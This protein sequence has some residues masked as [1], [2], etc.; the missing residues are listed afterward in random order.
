MNRNDD[1]VIKI[2]GSDSQA[3][4]ACMPS[5]CGVSARIEPGSLGLSCGAASSGGVS[6]YFMLS[7]GGAS[8]AGPLSAASMGLLA[9]ACSRGGVWLDGRGGRSLLAFR[10]FFL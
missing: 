4:S 7:A 8:A 10:R 9:R 3:L 5:P 2:I 6:G 1:N